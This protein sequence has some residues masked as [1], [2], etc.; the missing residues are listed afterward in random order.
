[1]FKKIHTW[2]RFDESGLGKLPDL[3]KVSTLANGFCLLSLV[4]EMEDIG[5]AHLNRLL[6]NL[7]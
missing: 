2:A 6:V 1:M 3:P 4:H 7:A 5:T